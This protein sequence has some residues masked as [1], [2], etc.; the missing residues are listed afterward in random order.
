MGSNY[1]VV[2]LVALSVV[3]PQDFHGTSAIQ[4]GNSYGRSNPPP[5]YT[6]GGMPPHQAEHSGRRLNL[7]VVLPSSHFKEKWYKSTIKASIKS[8]RRHQ[9]IA[10]LLKRYGFTDTHSVH[11]RT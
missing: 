6:G 7:G 8:V 5:K 11:L 10:G 3:L 1:Y 9:H 4:L 2:I